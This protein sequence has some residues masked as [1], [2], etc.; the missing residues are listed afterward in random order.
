MNGQKKVAVI[1]ASP[2]PEGQAA[3][4]FLAGIALE[5]LRDDATDVQVINARQALARHTEQ[6]AFRAMAEADALIIVFPL[7]VFCLPGITMRFLQSYSAYAAKL[8]TRREAAVYA[9]INCGFPEPGINEE[10]ARVIARFAA[11]VGARYGFSIL[12]GGGGMVTMSPPPVKKMV[13][14]YRETLRRIGAEIAAGKTG[15]R[16]SVS[17]RVAFPRKLYFLMGNVGWR[18]MIR[19]NGRKPGDLYARPYLPAGKA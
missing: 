8:E 9:V 10:A 14:Q 1:S 11:A 2:K 13:L 17:L 16:E 6:E 5:T 15:P 3:S 18:V 7:Y 19:R 4:D 12:I